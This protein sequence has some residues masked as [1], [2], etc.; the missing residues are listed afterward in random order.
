MRL[1]YF[2]TEFL[3]DC[4]NAKPFRG[5]DQIELNLSCEDNFHYD[6]ITNSLYRT[7]RKK[8]LP[9]NFWE[10]EQLKNKPDI[11]IQPN[12]RNLNVLA[13]ENGSGK[14]TVIQYVI[15]F[16]NDIYECVTGRA[17]NQA[18]HHNPW[19]NRNLLVFEGN[20]IRQNES[21]WFLF[22]Y[23]PSSI[24]SVPQFKKIGFSEDHPKTFH[25]FFCNPAELIELNRK[26]ITYSKPEQSYAEKR[27]LSLLK[28]TKIIYMTNTLTKRDYILNNN[29]E[30]F[31]RR[32]DFFVYDCSLGAKIGSN[33]S[34]FFAYEVYR[35]VKYVFD[36]KQSKLRK[37]LKKEIP[38]F[39]YPHALH[40]RPRVNEIR[41][42]FQKQIPDCLRPYLNNQNREG[43]YST[44]HLPDILSALCVAS[45][46]L[47]ADR[48]LDIPSHSNL[49]WNRTNDLQIRDIQTPKRWKNIIELLWN[50]VSNHIQHNYLNGS[51][52]DYLHNLKDLCVDYLNFLDLNTYTLF[53]RIQPN[54]NGED[55]ILTLDS[56][57]NDETL[58]NM[59]IAFIQKY[60]Y[61]CEP[62]Y[63]I[64]FDWG[65]SSGE[66]SM[67][68]LFSDLYYVFDRDY[69]IESN[70]AYNIYNNENHRYEQGN[71]CDTVILFLDEADL[72]LHP[73]WQRNL[74]HILTAFLPAIYPAPNIKDIQII[75]STHS[76]LL[77]GDVPEEN[78]TY[79][80]AGNQIHKGETSGMLALPGETFGQNI[81]VILKES[82]FLNKGTVGEFAANKINATARRLYEISAQNKNT[83]GQVSTEE[84]DSLRKTVS[85]VAP[86]ILRNQLDQFLHSAE[87][88]IYKNDE[89]M[90]DRIIQ[91]STKLSAKDR[92]RL[93]ESL[94]RQGEG[95]D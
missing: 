29:S 57:E 15:D 86:G 41:E 64:E 33:I 59:L 35:Q 17:W 88:F 70:G 95:H 63:T 61:T 23:V 72:T 38:V 1:L 36:G 5:L 83:L 84:M 34:H 94:R 10:N 87:K 56:I 14:S 6:K 22:D 13:G 52:K 12:I 21:E 78:I 9:K 60:R 82:F 40:I 48:L 7:A 44:S 92:E 3:D 53:S 77:L 50:A 18:G 67:L 4:G 89:Q 76:P 91:A 69:N 85:L 43:A 51:A 20:G 80:L 75:L 24:K 66:E 73:E 68:R 46:A 65:L 79:L 2:Y 81:H 93:M 42:M 74:I 11:E 49:L 39:P 30:M 28:N 31:D 19:V 71:P 58:Y 54:K 55:Y 16:L 8:P 45:Y 25:F 26:T 47:N 62:V 90:V 27:I 37:R 32:R